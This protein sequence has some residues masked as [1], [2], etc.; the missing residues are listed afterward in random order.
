MITT[1]V[2]RQLGYST[3]LHMAHQLEVHHLYLHGV[4]FKEYFTNGPDAWKYA[5][6]DLLAR[7]RVVDAEHQL[8][9]PDYEAEAKRL[10]FVATVSADKPLFGW[11]HPDLEIVSQRADYATYGEAWKSA[12]TWAKRFPELFNPS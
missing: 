4:R 11:R 2:L 5:E 3:Q 10:G 6:Q 9:G 1:S 7:T 8:P 12:Y